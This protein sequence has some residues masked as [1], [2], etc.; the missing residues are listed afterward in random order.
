[1]WDLWWTK[2]HWDRFS[3]S[4]SASPANLHSTNCSTITIIYHLGPVQYA[5][6]G[7][8]TKWTQSHLTKNNNNN[9]KKINCPYRSPELLHF[10]LQC[11]VQCSH[12][13]L[14][15][16]M[17]T[18]YSKPSLIRLQL[19]RMSNNLAQYMKNEKCCPQSST[20]FKWH[21]AFMKQMSDLS[22]QTKLDSSFKPTL[23][24]SKTITT[25]ESSIVE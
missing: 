23:F 20:Y 18:M 6:G 19:I 21:M 4:T 13:V 1:M 22:V 8:S 16:V 3:L 2:W 15:L 12:R 17:V 11:T 7:C 24:H 5:S 10:P 14:M 9:K 25:S